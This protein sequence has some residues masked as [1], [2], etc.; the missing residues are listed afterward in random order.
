MSE[1][2]VQ[3]T[4]QVREKPVE[5]AAVL[6]QFILDS[7]PDGVFALDEKHRVVF[8]SE[9]VHG[10]LGYHATELLGQNF[11]GLFA[12]P[13][14]ANEWLV[15]TVTNLQR[16]RQDSGRLMLR[17][18]D[19][20]SV[21]V[22]Y[23]VARPLP[24]A[25]PQIALIGTLRDISGDLE[26]NRVLTVRN[27]NL[28]T[29]SRFTA[30]IAEGG[31][32][33]PM[34]EKLLLILMQTLDLRAVAVYVASKDSRQAVLTAHRGMPRALTDRHPTVSL[35]PPWVRRLLD[36]TD[37]SRV[38]STAGVDPVIV[39]VLR[40]FHLEDVHCLAVRHK[41]RAGGGLLFIPVRPLTPMTNLCSRRLVHN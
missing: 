1:K 36:R 38:L 3:Q 20:R 16:R 25:D 40:E 21:A 26:S 35:D 24:G 8:A 11:V 29:L 12:D 37:A 4:I 30:I 6:P 31:E 18:R 7:L 17:R 33:R 41:G 23:S 14:A 27:R 5:R 10:L 13:S 22:G 19:L 32:L 9:V 2:D 34:L 39:G 28:A 15:A